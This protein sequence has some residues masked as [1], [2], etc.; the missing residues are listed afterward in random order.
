MIVSIPEGTSVGA[1]E[2]RG[3]N[4]LPCRQ[5]AFVPFEL[6]P[7]PAKPLQYNGKLCVLCG[8]MWGGVT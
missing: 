5:H 6:R 7:N 2:V 1:I 8:E 4:R 3:M